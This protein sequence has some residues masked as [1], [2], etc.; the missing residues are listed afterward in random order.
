MSPSQ[1]CAV[2][3]NRCG[4]GRRSARNLVRASLSGVTIGGCGPSWLRLPAGPTVEKKHVANIIAIAV[5]QRVVCSTL[6]PSYQLDR[7]LHH[8][9][10]QKPIEQVCFSPTFQLCLSFR[11]DQSESQ[12]A[13]ATCAMSH[14]I[15]KKQRFLPVSTQCAGSGGGSPNLVCRRIAPDSGCRM[16]V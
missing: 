10:W 14:G 5:R 2:T 13:C 9:S 16:H 7:R 8:S 11:Y 15:Q 6:L 3:A 12:T 4:D 1:S